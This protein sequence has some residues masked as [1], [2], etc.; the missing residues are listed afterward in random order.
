MIDMKPEMSPLPLQKSCLRR[1]DQRGSTRR[2]SP[3]SQPPRRGSQGI[4]PEPARARGASGASSL[5]G[6]SAG[7]RRDACTGLS[8]ARRLT[9]AGR[10]VKMVSEVLPAGA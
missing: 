5:R 6:W 2:E 1:R 8:E 9:E 7:G 3:R 10:I 4:R